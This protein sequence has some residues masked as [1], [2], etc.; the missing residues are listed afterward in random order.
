MA[1]GMMRLGQGNQVNRRCCL[2]LEDQALIGLALEASLEEAGF[3]VA[4]PFAKSTEALHWLQ[5]R[6]PDLALIDVLLQDGP[7]LPVARELRK[8]RVPFAIYSG[9]KAP[10]PTAPE[11][12]DVPWLEKPVPRDQ[13]SETLLKLARDVSVIELVKGGSKVLALS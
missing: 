2:I 12:E 4:G 13:L 10:C 9:L 1:S 3:A 11:F 8:R 7:C 6:T 5:E